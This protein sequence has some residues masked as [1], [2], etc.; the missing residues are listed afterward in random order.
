MPI[1]YVPVSLLRR[2]MDNFK[3]IGYG[4]KRGEKME[5]IKMG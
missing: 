4:T 2:T 1:T 5:Q 3:W